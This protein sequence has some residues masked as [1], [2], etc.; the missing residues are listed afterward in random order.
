VSRVTEVDGRKLLDGVTVPIVTPIDVV[1]HP[2]PTA[3]EP[4]LAAL[5]DA[6]ITKLL[7]LGT[8][9]EGPAFEA[10]ESAEFA[11]AV[12]ATWRRLSHDDVVV[13]VAVFGSST[14]ES[15]RR[16]ELMLTS[17]ADVLVVPPPHYFHYDADELVDFYRDLAALGLPVV[18]YNAARYTGNPITESVLEAACRVSGVVG[19]KDSGGDDALVL[20]AVKITHSRVDFGVSQ[21]NERRLA[22]ALQQGASGITPGL[23]NIAPQACLDLLAAVRSGRNDAALTMQ[24]KLDTLAAMHQIRPGVACM[25]AAVAILG[26]SSARTATPMRAYSAE[27]MA[28][29]RELLAAAPVRLIGD[30]VH[31]Q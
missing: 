14:R 5:A 28:A 24:A 2:D 31:P 26:M 1:G 21:G 4:Q 29:L 8:N 22:W 7:L 17:G 10:R 16:A 25:K 27:E 15:I 23:A 20:A 9:G 11:V 12:T 19:I 13:S 3:V 6:G 18:M 30:R